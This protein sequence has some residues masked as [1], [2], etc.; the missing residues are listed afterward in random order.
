MGD[1][2]KKKKKNESSR[3]A[4]VVILDPRLHTELSVKFYIPSIMIV[5]QIFMGYF[6]GT[7]K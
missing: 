1:K 6:I 3:R 7:R 2:A 4:P 5:L